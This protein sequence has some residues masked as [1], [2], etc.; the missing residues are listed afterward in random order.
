VVKELQKQ[1][2]G[3][4]FRE[5]LEMQIN[6][7]RQEIDSYKNNFENLHNENVELQNMVVDLQ[8]QNQAMGER[9]GSTVDRSKF[10][11]LAS[12]IEQKEREI[13]AMQN[14]FKTRSSNHQGSLS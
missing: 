11:Q 14:D 3:F 12:L 13:Q 6:E 10:E 7:Y 8:N 5:Q 9:F 2:E 1:Q 4:E